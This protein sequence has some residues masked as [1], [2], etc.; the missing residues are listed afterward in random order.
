MKTYFKA[1]VDQLVKR[2][3]V[4]TQDQMSGRLQAELLFANMFCPNFE[5]YG[6]LG[7]NTKIGALFACMFHLVTDCQEV[8]CTQS[9][10]EISIPSFIDEVFKFTYLIAETT[11]VNVNAE[12]QD[13]LVQKE[14]STE[15]N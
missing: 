7:S 13:F 10:T 12:N 2:N 15:S 1:E 5:C 14:K 4:K 8:L 11:Q 6:I 9:V 3:L